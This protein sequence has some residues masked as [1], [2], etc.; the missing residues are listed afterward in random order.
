MMPEM[1]ISP[2]CTMPFSVT[3]F[4]YN[5]RC[6]SNAFTAT[7][8]PL[9]EGYVR[10][11]VLF[12]KMCGVFFEAHSIALVYGVV[13]GFILFGVIKAV[14]LDVEEVPLTPLEAEITQYIH[15]NASTGCTA[16]MI[17][18][19]IDQCY[20]EHPMKMEAVNTALQT[21][22]KRGTILSVPTTVWVVSGN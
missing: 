7:L 9:F 14:F 13:L 1:S 6:Y 21:L 3:D 15:T 16:K 18:K 22:K 4:V 17:Y 20:E 8:N 5:T 2:V 12:L 10:I 19:H 11:H